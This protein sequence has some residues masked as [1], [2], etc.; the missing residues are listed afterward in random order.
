MRDEHLANIAYLEKRITLSPRYAEDYG[1]EMQTSQYV[2]DLIDE[3]F[4]IETIGWEN[5]Y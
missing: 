4:P 5:Y 2:V 1:N 3:K